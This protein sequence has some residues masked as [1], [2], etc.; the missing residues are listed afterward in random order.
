MTGDLQTWLTRI[1]AAGIIG[2]CV[3]IYARLLRRIARG[4][5]KAVYQP[6]GFPDLLVVLVL[7][8]WLGGMAVNGFTHPT[9]SKTMNNKEIVESVALFGVLVGGIV[10]FLSCRNIPVNRLFGFTRVRAG[11]VI[12]TAAGLLLAAF[13]LTKV[14]TNIMQYA[15]G[16]Q[17]KPQEILDYFTKSAQHAHWLSVAATALA[18]TIAAPLAEEFLF[19]GYIYT[20]LRR[21]L[22]VGPAMLLS[23]LL[24]GGIHVNAVAFPALCVL[25]VCLSIAYETTGSLAV[26]MA[27]HA[28][29]NLVNLG[30]NLLVTLWP[31]LFSMQ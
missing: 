20:V 21:F 22:G 28:A 27:M 26:P 9:E 19:R 24:F 12:A 14:C 16:D 30:L 4:Y 15:L 5:G 17:A 8:I 2:V 6:L 1:L 31:N 11:R 3:A 13:P 7:G 23:A 29:F 10:F 25:A 18:A